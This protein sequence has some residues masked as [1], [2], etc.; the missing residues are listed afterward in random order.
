[1]HWQT[2]V[3]VKLGLE[4]LKAIS[5][6]EKKCL[7]D[8]SVVQKAFLVP[9][10]LFPITLLEPVRMDLEFLAAWVLVELRS[11]EREVESLWSIRE[12]LI[13]IQELEAEYL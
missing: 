6:S 11:Q 8:R 3:F 2:L 12:Q 10:W 1:M 7:V 5:V 4:K 13:K 9:L